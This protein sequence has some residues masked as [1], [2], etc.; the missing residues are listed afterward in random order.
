MHRIG[1]GYDIH[2]LKEPGPLKIGGIII[3]YEKSLKGHSDGDV[4]L[5]AISDAMLGAAAKGDIGIFFPPDNAEYRGIDSSIILKKALSV[6]MEAGFHVVNI[7]CVIVAQKPKLSVYY[8]TLS[9]SISKLLDID[10]SFVSVKAKT[11]E[12][13]DAT[14]REEAISAYAIVLLEN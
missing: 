4:V 2:E 9:G 12:G 8:G 7:D 11:N 1:I 10:A 13:L 3:P 5:H 6:V 14:G